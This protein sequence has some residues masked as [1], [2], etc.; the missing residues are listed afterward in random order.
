MTAE[1][2]SHYL[3]EKPGALLW[4]GTTK[5]GETNIHYI[6]AIILLMKKFFG[7]EVLF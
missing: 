1:D 6:V 5:E 4:I 3:L 7:K 2:F